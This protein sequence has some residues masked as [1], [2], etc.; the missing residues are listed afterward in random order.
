MT[1]LIDQVETGMVT[2]G[3][4]DTKKVDRPSPGRPVRIAR[5]DARWH[6]I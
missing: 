6:S 4:R 3:A 5:G 2:V 1:V